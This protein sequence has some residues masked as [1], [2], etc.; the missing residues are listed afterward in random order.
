LQVRN[1]D[2][3]YFSANISGRAALNLLYKGAFSGSGQKQGDKT[4][5]DVIPSQSFTIPVGGI[6]VNVGTCA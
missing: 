1:Y 2:I 6:P 4:Y 3:K 5:T